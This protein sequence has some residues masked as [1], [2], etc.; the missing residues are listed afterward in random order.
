MESSSFE[1]GKNQAENPQF[2]VEKFLAEQVAPL[3]KSLTTLIQ[4]LDGVDSLEGYLEKKGGKLEGSRLWETAIRIRS[5]FQAIDEIGALD[6]ESSAP[7]TRL[8][9]VLRHD[10]FAFIGVYPLCA[11]NVSES[12]E[13]Q[14]LIKYL[15][16]RRFI[17][18]TKACLEVSRWALRSA[19]FIYSEKK[20]RK[21]QEIP[22]QKL[23]YDLKSFIYFVTFCKGLKYSFENQEI[24]I[25]MGDRASW[26]P[27]LVYNLIMNIISNSRKRG[28]AE[29][30]KVVIRG[31]ERGCFLVIEIQDDGIGIPHELEE[32][33]FQ[34]GFTTFE[35]GEGL[36]LGSA[37]E[38]MG[39]LNEKIEV[40][41]HGGLPTK[42]GLRVCKRLV[43]GN[44]GVKTVLKIPFSDSF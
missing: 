11:I 36:G 41:G 14:A 20:E 28:E 42:E 21:L 22:V 1:G 31:E 2:K 10:L 24:A 7:L 37:R 18:R 9:R 4:E 16:E 19:D 23:I 33:I 12:K 39:L 13:G 6:L 8:I 35:S 26:Y 3:G 34:E 44:R 32:K 15:D 30:I 17:P 38:L 29:E 43:R 27:E 25:K 40:E 5:F